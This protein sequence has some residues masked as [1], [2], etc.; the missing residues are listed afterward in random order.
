MGSPQGASRGR[1]TDPSHLSS[2][3]S[4]VYSVTLIPGDGVGKEI[5]QAVEEIFEVRWGGWQGQRE[6]RTAKL[7][8]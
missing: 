8:I 6:R 3:N 5:T 2:R 1:T 7:T 4:G